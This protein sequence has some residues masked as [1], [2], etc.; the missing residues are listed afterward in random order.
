MEEDKTQIE[1]LNERVKKLE[2]E[3]KQIK[4]AFEP[5][6]YSERKELLKESFSRALFE[7]VASGQE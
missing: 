7:F 3:I 1:I 2:F 5:L 4:Q 6:P